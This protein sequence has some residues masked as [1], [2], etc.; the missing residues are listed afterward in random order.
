MTDTLDRRRLLERGGVAA[1]GI[2]LFA[3]YQ[4]RT[5]YAS[6]TTMPAPSGADDSAALQN[7]LN[8]NG[9]VRFDAY[10]RQ[11]YILA[12]VMVPSR[13]KIVGAGPGNTIFKLK[14]NA[15]S[16][17]AGSYGI[18]L[19][20]GWSGSGD[21]DISIEGVEFDGNVLNNRAAEQTAGCQWY[22][23]R[24][25]WVRDC[26]FH[27]WRGEG[28]TWRIHNTGLVLPEDVHVSDVV[29]NNMG[30]NGNGGFAG[31]LRQGLFVKAGRN[32]T[33]KGITARL[34]YSFTI[35][36][37]GG[38]NSDL[39]QGI[40]IDDVACYDCY[41]GIAVGSPAGATD[42]R[43]SNL[44]MRDGPTLNMTQ[45]I[46]SEEGT[47]RLTVDNVSGDSD[48]AGPVVDIAT[49]MDATLSNISSTGV[50]A[51]SPA[52]RLNNCQGTL[53]TGVR[54][55]GGGGQTYAVEEVGNSDNTVVTAYHT[56]GGSKGQTKFVGDN[57]RVR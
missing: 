51:A 22:G 9:E 31:N 44:T 18:F 32:M 6:T 56:L 8:N 27:D 37:E 45:A 36:L 25:M 52:I 4:P 11:P 20:A 5:V 28:M 24:R 33:F 17:A 40:T 2:A 34:C 3:G 38:N 39:L 43:V 50:K 15:P 29:L 23:T 57:S 16:N 30:S 1:L 48:F 46:H 42:C 26:Y 21:T 47:I 12:N 55:K 14:D 49:A 10:P 35:D 7:A 53:I 13:S 41:G 54:L 19:N